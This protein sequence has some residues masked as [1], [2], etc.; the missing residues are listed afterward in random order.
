MIREVGKKPITSQKRAGNHLRVGGWKVNSP[1]KQ[2]AHS[3]EAEDSLKMSERW[4]H[5]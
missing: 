2:E 4:K 1:G 5:L 3:C